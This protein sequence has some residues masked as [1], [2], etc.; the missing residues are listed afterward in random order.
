MGEAFH[1]PRLIHGM[2]Q[3]V[4]AKDVETFAKS[5]PAPNRAFLRQVFLQLT[6]IIAGRWNCHLLAGERP[7]LSAAWQVKSQGSLLHPPSGQQSLDLRVRGRGLA[8]P[9]EEAQGLGKCPAGAVGLTCLFIEANQVGDVC[10]ELRLATA[11]DGKAPPASAH[12][13]GL[14]LIRQINRTQ[15]MPTSI[16]IY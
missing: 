6:G 3:V 7:R 10:G 5:E 16:S 8:G 2:P 9:R 4:P 14:Q 13:P 11:L 1:H 15:A 12:Q